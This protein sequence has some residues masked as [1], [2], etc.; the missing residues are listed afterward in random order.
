MH[1]YYS[2]IKKLEHLVGGSHLLIFLQNFLHYSWPFTLSC[3]LWNQLVEPYTKHAG[4]FDLSQV[5]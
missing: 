3:E 2:F 4:D 1:N 5:D